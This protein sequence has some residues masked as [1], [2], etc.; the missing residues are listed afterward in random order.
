MVERPVISI[1]NFLVAAVRCILWQSAC[2]CNLY[3]FVI[4]FLEFYSFSID[5][6][7]GDAGLVVLVLLLE[8]PG[9]HYACSS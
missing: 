3:F 6:F 4:E 9:G 5:K 7:K 2:V 8:I 1:N